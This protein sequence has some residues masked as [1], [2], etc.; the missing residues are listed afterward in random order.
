LFSLPPLGLDACWQRSIRALHKILQ[1]AHTV[2][3]RLLGFVFEAVCEQL[4]H[5]LIGADLALFRLRLKPSPQWF[6]DA[7]VD[8]TGRTGPTAARNHQSS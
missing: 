5:Q 3:E 4:V 1:T 8:L 2:F 6:V 7:Q